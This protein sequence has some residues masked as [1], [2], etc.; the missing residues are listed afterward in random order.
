MTPTDLDRLALD[1]GLLAVDMVF[2][3]PLGLFLSLL[4]LAYGIEPEVH[5][6]CSQM[7]NLHGE[8]VQAM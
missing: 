7:I 2:S 4:C 1:L 5:I 6:Y 3:L 8:P